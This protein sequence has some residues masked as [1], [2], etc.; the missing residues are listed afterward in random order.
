MTDPLESLKRELA[1]LDEQ[2]DEVKRRIRAEVKRLK[3]IA[4]SE[5]EEQVK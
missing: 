2:R 4:K 3:G 5:R 1:A